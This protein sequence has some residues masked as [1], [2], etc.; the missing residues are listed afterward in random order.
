MNVKRMWFPTHGRLTRR[1]SAQ[2]RNGWVFR[3]QVASGILG[4]ILVHLV[5][6][7]IEPLADIDVHARLRRLPDSTARV[8]G[9]SA[10]GYP[11]SLARAVAAPSGR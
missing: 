8:P 10:R 2:R 4:L 5:Y 1:V 7:H 6:E 9:R 3:G 11:G